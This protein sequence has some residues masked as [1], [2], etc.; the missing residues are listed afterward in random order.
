MTA[1]S[2]NPSDTRPHPLSVLEK[3]RVMGGAALLNLALQMA[4]SVYQVVAVGA[5]VAALFLASSWI[6][7]PFLGA[8]YEQTMLFNGAPPSA[9]SAAWSLYNQGVR[10]GDQLLS[11]NG[12]EV[13]SAAPGAA[14]PQQ[15]FPRR[16]PSGQHSHGR[17][18]PEELH[19]YA[20]R[21]PGRR[22]DGLL[23]A[24]DCRQPVLPGPGPVDLLDASRRIRRPFLCHPV[25]FGQPLRRFL[26]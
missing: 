13:H 26:L 14:D 12:V 8:L 15:P 6:K 24:A 4:A 2:T 3:V 10:F 21:L 16:E 7:T 22:P 23:Y 25:R 5:F 20:E 9:D 19:R 18:C 11:V 17:R 1:T